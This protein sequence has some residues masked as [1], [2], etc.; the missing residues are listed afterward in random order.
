MILENTLDLNSNQKAKSSHNDIESSVIRKTV[1]SLLWL[2]F[3]SNLVFLIL[4]FSNMPEKQ[5]K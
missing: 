1:T 4:N 2:L 5:A 3:V